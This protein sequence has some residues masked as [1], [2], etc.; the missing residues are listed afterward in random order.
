MITKWLKRIAIL[1]GLAALAYAI[2]WV[3]VFVLVFIR[4]FEKDHISDIALEDN[5]ELNIVAFTELVDKFNSANMDVIHPDW[6][7]PE[8]LISESELAWFRNQFQILGIRAGIRKLNDNELFLISTAKGLSIGGSSKGYIFNPKSDG[9]YYDNL[10]TKP[11]GLPE[12]TYGYRRIND[13]W[14]LAYSWND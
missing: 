2:Y 13:K 9:R 11:V 5:L 10:D 6:V 12:L 3:S 8:G 4:P 1:S 7:K 14:A